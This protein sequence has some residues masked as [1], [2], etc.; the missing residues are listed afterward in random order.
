MSNT[1]VTI[2]APSAQTQVSVSSA[3]IIYVSVA[4][5]F[6][7]QGGNI[8]GQETYSA[9]QPISG[10]RVV[11]VIS[12]T[13]DYFDPEGEYEPAGI[14]KNAAAQGDTLT[15]ALNGPVVIAGWGLTPGSTYY[16]GPNGTLIS[17]ATQAVG[18]VQIIGVAEDANTLIVN[19]Q[20]GI[21]L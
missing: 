14:A 21:I 8:G 1:I 18:R 16:A 13:A 5:G 4:A 3:D 20:Q 11:T 10:G 15:V 6:T 9:A 7:G 12:N 19:I 2:G 17:D